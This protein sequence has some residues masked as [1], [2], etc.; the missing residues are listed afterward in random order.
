MGTGVRRVLLDP[1]SASLAAVT[2]VVLVWLALGIGGPRISVLVCWSVMPM[3][4]L[5]LFVLAR[6]VCAMPA[7]APAPRRFWRAAAAAG[8]IFAL[9]D[10]Y[11]L[12][13]TVR[14]PAARTLAPGLIQS[15]S[16]I[17]GAAVLVG[18][19]LLYPNDVGSGRARAR[20]LLDAGTILTAAGVVAW[21]LVTRPS[22]SGA[23]PDAF[24]TAV[25]GS[26]VLLVGVF[27][28]VKLGLGG[29]S[30]MGVAAAAPMTVAAATQGI[31]NIIVPTDTAATRLPLHLVLILAP[32][33]L[34]AM[35]PRIQ[36]LQH[37]WD[38]AD[39]ARAGRRRYSLLPYAATALTFA[40][41]IG[42]L[43]TGLHLSGWGALV[44][45][46]LN[47]GL[48]ILRQVLALRENEDLLGRLDASLLEIT[49]REARLDS[50]LRHSSDITSVVDRAGLVAYVSPA[51]Q[52][53]LGLRPAD[54]LDKPIVD[55]LHPGDLEAIRP[56]WARL[57]AEP[58]AVV[59]YQSRYR[60]AEGAWRWLEVTAT[61]LIGETAVDGIVSN[62][63][64]VTEAREL[65]DQLRHQ[66]THDVLT[67][68][69]NRRLFAE[70]M[71]QAEQGS[72]AVL[73]IDLD[74]F[75]EINDTYGHSSGDE[76]LLRV[77]AFLRDAAGPGDLVARFGGDEFAVLI[78]GGDE[79]A[80]REVASRFL[81]AIAVPADIAGRLL[82]IRASVGLVAGRAADAEGLLHAADMEMY[83]QKR[84]SA[85]R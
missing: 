39:R 28:A 67:G 14:D 23:R 31:A 2:V 48:V 27:T 72:A 13:L 11:Q 85:A 46:T 66:A 12:L 50:L 79:L 51:V 56:Q 29:S 49:R 75:K 44:G 24:F 65:H 3:A 84:R 35:G 74:G 37:R 19:T 40:T 7:T 80:A 81:D 15:I 83:A 26:G 5:A 61:N 76:V 59:T 55:F 16:A 4:D 38:P 58:G 22:V 73:L 17:G 57:I 20:F 43:R 21:C 41:F 10:G 18:V 32:A 77:A 45:L 30:P 69:A 70:R 8:L 34:F 71:Q 60:N 53:T 6:R 42:V 1:V 82:T 52:R 78:S 47:V 64:D 33:L 25:V 54:V 63:R 9:G 68:L 36:E 62:A